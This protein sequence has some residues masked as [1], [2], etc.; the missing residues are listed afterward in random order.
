M[1]AGTYHCPKGDFL[2]RRAALV[3]D[4]EICPPHARTFRIDCTLFP[5]AGSILPSEFAIDG[6]V[7]INQTGAGLRELHRDWGG[8]WSLTGVYL[9]LAILS[10]RFRRSARP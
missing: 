10:A 6:L 3:S 4:R 2:R 5:A 7:S 8:L 9:V 1:P